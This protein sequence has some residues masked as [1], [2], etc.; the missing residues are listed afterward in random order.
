MHLPVGMQAYGNGHDRVSMGDQC[1]EAIPM[2]LAELPER[3]KPISQG[4]QIAK[5]KS[6]IGSTCSWQNVRGF[7]FF[8]CVLPAPHPFPPPPP[9]APPFFPEEKKVCGSQI[10][11]EHYWIKTRLFFF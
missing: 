6:Q 9:R 4:E 11:V 1:I 7:F 8:F 3:R 2:R 5:W 10:R